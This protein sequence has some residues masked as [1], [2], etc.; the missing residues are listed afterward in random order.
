MICSYK[1]IP[2]L[3]KT[4]SGKKIVFVSGCF[5]IIHPGHIEFLEKAASLGDVLVVG[6]LAD[7]YIQTKKKRQAVYSQK[8][9]A[10]IVQSLKPVTCVVLTPYK[11]GAYP[12]LAILQTLRPNIFFRQEK[13]HAYLPLQ[14]ELNKLGITL[15]ALSMKK[16]HSTTKTI[17]KVLRMVL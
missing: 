13:E 16:V 1:D 4:L 11:K 3:R 7:A 10:Q 14:D 15:K 17:Q 9:R 2:S 12:S 6:V 5:D 8:Q